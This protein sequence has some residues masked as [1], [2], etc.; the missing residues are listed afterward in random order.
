MANQWSEIQAGFAAA[1]RD[2][3]LPTPTSVVCRDRK[4][5]THRFAVYRNNSAVSL[6]DALA[7][8]Y[9]V[10]RELVGEA[11]FRAMAQAFVAQNL[12]QSPVLIEYGA[13]FPEFIAAFP[14]AA[15]LDFLAELARVERAWREAYHAADAK[16]LSLTALGQYDEGV[17]VD[18][19]LQLHPSVRLVA[20][21]YPVIS[22]W[23]AHNISGVDERQNVLRAIAQRSEGGMIV[24]P[25]AD[26]DVQWLV[27]EM[28]ELLAALG[29]GRSLGAAAE[30]AGVATA[31]ELGGMLR[32][33]FETGAVVAI[34]V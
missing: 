11:F 23:Q 13:D 6:V 31:D 5:S 26:V 15:E 29:E 32:F 33:A 17:V 25:A 4:I 12:P 20:S 2:P 28:F 16:P 10:V 1:V 34:N 9:P 7:D 18:A 22:I 24:R 19:K 30:Q 14:P 3:D 8:S 27:P 21:Q